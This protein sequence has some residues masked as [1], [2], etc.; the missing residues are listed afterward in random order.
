MKLKIHN[1]IFSATKEGI[2]IKHKNAIVFSLNFTEI[3]A[4]VST[5]YTIID[6]IN[7]KMK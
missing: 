2:I 3:V 7:D 4:I 6:L 5:I 1:M